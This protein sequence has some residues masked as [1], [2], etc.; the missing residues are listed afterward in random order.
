MSNIRRQSIISS[1]IVYVG[2]A[3]GFLNTYLFTREGGFAREDYGMTGV[4]ISIANVMYS[5]SSVGMQAYILKFYPFYKSNLEEKENDMIS[6]AL[7]TSLVGFAL[8]VCGGLIFKGWVLQQYAVNSPKL[9]KYYFWLFPF[10]LGLTYFSL[11]EAFAWHFQKSILTNFLREVLFRLLTTLLIVLTFLGIIK[12]F[13]LFIKL[14]ACTYL[15][16]AGILALFLIKSGH[17]HFTFT[18][19][20]VTRK[21]YR[22]IRSLALFIWSANF[23]LTISQ[24]VDSLLIALL[25][26]DGLA[27]AA[28]YTLAQNI[29]SLIQAPQRG[30]I[31]ASIASV[32]QAW[33]EKDLPRIGRIYHR[34]SINQIIF[35]AAMFTLIWMNFADGVFTFHLQKEFL[36]AKMVFLYIGLMRIVDMGTG[37]NSQ[38]I[39]TSN[40]W[41]FDF[42]TGII[43][44]V[45]TLPLNY[46]LVKQLGVTGPAIANLMSMIVYNALRYIFLYR[47]FG[48]QPFSVESLYPFLL[49]I[50]GY[51]IC[52]W[53]FA[54]QQGLAWIILRSL[55]FL[56]I[57][58]PAILLLN[59]SPDIIPVYRTVL[60]RLG[61]RKDQ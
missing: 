35:A 9:V 38:I 48:L 52:T 53:L 56:A 59:V 55:V 11:L 37:V 47:K 20:R 60:K 57:Y 1:V 14:F 46:F 24:F 21:F 22:K 42:L 31:T 54:N 43:L 51:L 6:W 34:S 41:R 12:S 29:A 45:I 2:F 23:S 8:V 49:A 58:I 5:L 15:F 32:A 3:L 16:L 50:A 44:I 36:D 27:Y 39:A 18:I 19:S 25:L 40:F 7:L 33:K 26:K 17:L 28:I 30:I 4:F 10:G 13:D 61:L